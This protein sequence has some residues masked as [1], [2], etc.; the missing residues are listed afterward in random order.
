[1]IQNIL[2][3]NIYAEL[4]CPINEKIRRLLPGQGRYPRSQWSGCDGRKIS[5]RRVRTKIVHLTETPHYKFL[6]G[7]RKLYEEYMNKSGWS[8]Y[9]TQH[10]PE[11]FTKLSRFFGIYLAK[12]YENNHIICKMRD[13]K[14]VIV[15]G[16]HRMSI[17]KFRNPNQKYIKIKV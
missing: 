17:I 7:D 13:G 1:M 16:L 4:V 5:K 3:E 15:D 11:N 2:I 14:Y 10:S 8:N 9:G 12:P 6:S